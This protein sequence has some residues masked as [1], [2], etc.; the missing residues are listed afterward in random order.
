[1]PADLDQHYIRLLNNNPE[2][3]I[4]SIQILIDTI[5]GRFLRSGCFNYQEKEDLKQQIN[6]ELLKKIPKLQAQYNGKSTLTTYLSAV[7][8]NICYEILRKNKKNHLY[9]KEE[10]QVEY[11]SEVMDTFI[12]KEEIKL[13]KNALEL[14]YKQKSRLILFLKLKYRIPLSLSDFKKVYIQI[15]GKE[16]DD[17][18]QRIDPFDLATDVKIFTELVPFIKK[19]ENKEVTPDSIRKWIKQ[20]TNELIEIMNGDPPVSNY[21]EE[22]LQILF[23]KYHQY[24]NEMPLKDSV[25]YEI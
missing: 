25:Y 14:F 17:F 20:K 23:E 10:F 8:V 1:M 22:T 3:L 11:G 4:L 15:T 2:K 24:Q 21:N 13:F 12:I 6:E 9:I 7:I 16:F 18:I 19:Y 5:V